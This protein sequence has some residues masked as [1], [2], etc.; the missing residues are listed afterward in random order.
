MSERQIIVVD[1]ETTGL[2]AA[3]HVPV[4]IAW[5]NLDTGESGCFVSPHS[6]IDIANAQPKALEINGYHERISE[7]PHD[8]GVG[9]S[10]LHNQLLD[11]TLAGSNPT[12]DS[13]MLRIAF[14]HACYAPLDPWHH[15]LLD[16]SA[17][18]AG[19]L[20]L[21]P[22]ALPGLSTVCELLDVVNTAPHTAMGDVDATAE[23]FRKLMA[24]K[25]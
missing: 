7:L 19:V 3:I 9:V 23:C 1:V 25:R 17:Y 21:H 5:M 14:A 22:W 20:G 11:N 13:L 6:S 18:T 4:E 8:K 16:L 2:N 10:Q 24:V 15:R 12:F